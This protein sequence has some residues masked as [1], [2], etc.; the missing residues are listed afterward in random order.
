MQK[1]VLLQLLPHGKE[2]ISLIANIFFSL[3]QCQRAKKSRGKGLASPPPLA[4]RRGKEK[5]K[6]E[7]QEERKARRKNRDGEAEAKKG[8]KEKEK[9]PYL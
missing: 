4:G 1:P 8:K 5:R 6:E 9:N 3:F 7:R 2:R